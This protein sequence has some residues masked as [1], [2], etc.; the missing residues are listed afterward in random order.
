MIDWSASHINFVIA[1]YAI[2]FIVL[3]VIVVTTLMR[4]TTL[5]KTLAAMK[6]PDTGHKDAT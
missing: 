6:L 4:A 5:K 1:A 3:A 2:V